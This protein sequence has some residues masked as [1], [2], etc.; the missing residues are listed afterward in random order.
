MLAVF[1]LLITLPA[2]AF[3]ICTAFL[4]RN[5]LRKDKLRISLL[6]V[7][8]PYDEANY[9]YQ[10]SNIKTTGL[11][12]GSAVSGLLLIVSLIAY[13]LLISGME[14]LSTIG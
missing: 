1:V 8:T 5:W 11:L 4:I 12:V 9:N 6:N 2:L 13:S 14:Y 3:I 7:D 10:L